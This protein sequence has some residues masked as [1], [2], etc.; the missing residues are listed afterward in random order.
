MF[1]LDIA[2]QAQRNTF[3]RQVL[4]TGQHSQV[5]VMC[6]PPGGEIG[7]EV[8]ET[9]DQVLI[10]VEGVG[11]AILNGE[12]G[13]V[14]PGRLVFVPAGTRHNFINTGSV[15]MRLYTIY[16]PPEHAPG[17]VHR[18][19]AEAD[20]AE[21]APRRRP[22]RRAGRHPARRRPPLARFP[23]ASGLAAGA[24]ARRE[25]AGIGHTDGLMPLEEYRRKRDFA[26]TPEPAA[27]R[28]SPARPGASSSSA[29]AR[30]GSTTTSAS[31]SRASS[32]S[33]AV[34]KGPT[35]DPTI[36]R[37][38]VHVEDH[39]IEYF[40][41]EGVIPA[42][43]Y[44]A[45]DVIVWDW[46]T[47]EPE[48]PT[49]D[50][51]EGRRRRRA[52]VPPPR[53]EAEGPL[54]DR[55]DQPPARRGAEHRLRG[56]PGRAVAAHPQEGRD[57]AARLG[58]RGPPAERQDRP[59][60]RRGQGRPRRPLDQPGAGRDRR[61]RPRRRRGRA[62]ARPHRAD[63]R[64]PRL[65][66]VQRP[67]LAVR[68]QV[69]RLPRPGGRR[70]TARSASGPA[71]STT[72]RPTSRACSARRRWIDAQRG[73]RRRRGRRARRRRA[74]RLLASSRRELG[75]K[76]RDGARLPGVRPALP[77][78]ALAARRAARGP[79]APA[80][81]RAASDH[82]RVRFAAHVDG[83]G[84][85]FLEAAQASRA[86]GHHRQAPPLALRAGPA[87]ATPG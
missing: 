10:F 80:Q 75:E 38:A 71:T 15:D 9:V 56:R 86:R 5:V 55:P 2:E 30:P 73:D 68:D 49:L 19:K 48:A 57:L 44:G 13:A 28:P 81:E 22:D 29:T 62:D 67:G 85:A 16:A 4:S 54:H 72:P 53:R 84:M 60:Q 52:E 74:A 77:R 6:I 32:S 45:G 76:A 39:P 64:D 69:G 47:W 34:P 41:F 42:K 20:A 23:P 63:A 31:R 21:G 78:R 79:Q 43:Q 40:D 82:P 36:R 1:D 26:K 83:E 58:R 12:H 35:L 24:I 59:D 8:H 51:Q 17:T 61:D 11:E 3:F 7:D 87:V 37:M 33:W 65:E 18:T 25:S 70:P 50:P 14:L 46:G 27:G 66:A